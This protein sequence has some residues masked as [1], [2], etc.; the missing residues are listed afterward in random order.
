MRRTVSAGIVA[1]LTTAASLAAPG[2]AWP[3]EKYP[4]RPI[5]LIVPYAPGG[6]TDIMFRNIVKVIEAHKLVAVPIAIVNKTGGSGAVGKSHMIRSKPDG[7]VLGAVDPNNV[8]QQILGEASWDY[9]KDFTYIAKMVD[10]V[11]LLIV[12]KESPL[13]TLG[14]LVA[15]I[16][17]RGPKK[18]SIAG[19]AT[20]SQDHIASL[21][22]NKAIGVE[23]NYLP[24]K[25][26]GEVMT[27]LLGGHVD[28][29]WANPNECIGQLE[30]GTVR[31]LG[32]ADVKRLEL[33]PKIPTFKEQGV[34]MTS[35][36]WRGFGGPAGLP[37]QIVDYWVDV[38]T[39]VRKT[40]DW[41]K[42]YLEKFVL[43]DGWVVKEEFAK[44]M[45]QEYGAYREIFA[46]LGMLKK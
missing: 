23:A 25:S 1:L 13:K 8:T 33:L 21:D 42:G 15:E 31:A 14:E 27:T 4:S 7:Y 19:T 2:L 34:D 16:K 3:Q 46:K 30:A 44:L 9:R 20:A 32:V 41:Q 28:A 40:Q 22:L 17:R 18:L 35:Y 12:R 26:G 45:D 39:K 43:P 24:V 6:G 5:E 36:L 11:N 37:R 38:L 10:D 29:A